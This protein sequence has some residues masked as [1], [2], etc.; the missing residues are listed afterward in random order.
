MQVIFT[1]GQLA[2]RSDFYYQLAQ[3][4]GAGLGVVGALKHL[5]RS[6]PARSYRRPITQLLEQLADGQT[7][8][9][10]LIQVPGWLPE[11]DVALM[12]AGEKSGRLEA[13][14]GLLRDYYQERAQ[15]ARN[16]IGGLIYPAFLFHFAIFIFPFPKLFLSGDWGA[17]L[18]QVLMVLVPLYTI[19]GLIIFA[20]QSG[21]GAAW[22]S[23][24]E[25]LLRPIPML[26]TARHYLALARLSA[27]LEALLNA[28]VTVIE[29]WEM[30]ARASGS[31]GLQR[32]VTA[33]RPRL[34]GGETPS[35]VVRTSRAFPELFASQYM[36]GEISGSLDDGLKRL[37]RYYQE[38]AS[39]KLQNL[40]RW[41]P[42]IVYLAVVGMVVYRILQFW[43]GYFQT[44]QNVMGP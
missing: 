1:P 35:E 7:L 13:C 38:E 24:V 3:L 16:I 10:A 32:T 6:P 19:V 39:R 23:L 37:Q 9:D 21:H 33:W 28:G 14:V 26:G 8:G 30:A 15:L 43:L 11:F 29:A 34:D 4:T 44:L 20:G 42:Q 40:S 18:R 2:R 22:R 12:T 41:L 5:E 36:A 27:A 17:Y 25:R 31:F